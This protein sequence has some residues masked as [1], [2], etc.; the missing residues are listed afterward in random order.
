MFNDLV[1]IRRSVARAG[2]EPTA[3]M[4]EPES[5]C[6]FQ[7]RRR[8]VPH[9]TA[10]HS[11]PSMPC[12]HCNADAR[13]YNASM[14]LARPTGAWFFFAPVLVLTGCTAAAGDPGFWFFACLALLLVAWGAWR[15]G[16]MQAATALQVALRAEQQQRLALEQ[17]QDG[18]LWQ[19]DAAMVVVQ[20]RPARGS[21]PSHWTCEQ[22]LGRD[23]LS[24]FAEVKPQGPGLE[25]TDDSTTTP[26]LKAL[27]AARGLV[28]SHP[29]A[30]QL[31]PPLNTV[32]CALSA[33]PV[34][35]GQ[36][37]F[38]GYLGSLCTLRSTPNASPPAELP[39]H[40]DALSF[41]FTLSHDLRAPVRVVEGFTRIIKEDYAH[42]LDRVGL[43]HLDRVMGAAA[44]M[45]QMIDAML[46]VAKLTTQ[47][48]ARQVVNLS[49]L[50]NFVVEDLRR[51]E[52]DRQINI[53]IEAGLVV[54]GDPTLL[55]Q[56]L[57]NLLGN[58]WKYTQRAAQPCMQLLREQQGGEVVYVVK[59]NGAGFDMRSVDRLFGLFQR[60]HSANDFPG[61]GVGLASVK[62]IVARHGGRIWAQAEPGQGAAFHF[63]LRS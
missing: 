22:W 34:H 56:L 38:T 26:P 36:G 60:L 20:A 15:L 51:G 4:V 55:R 37:R 39:S 11:L 29:V 57:D 24:L 9:A 49:Q 43:D 63:T 30:L 44:R 59:D 47:P 53:D 14:H 35:D 25:A 16:R 10:H 48:V 40:D 42:Q 19:C 61:T 3:L 2:R 6:I 50:A 54:Q 33:S 8:N 1:E 12:M 27:T 23:L 31:A 5:P 28:L 18:V 62:R 52:P 21:A 58:A 41:G 32:L 45:N 17:L 46:A 13:P 7:R